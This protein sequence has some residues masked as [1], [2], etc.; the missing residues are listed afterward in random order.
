MTA[1]P[2]PGAD[3]S[4]YET[5]LAQL[6]RE[7]TAD[8]CEQWA[9]EHDSDPDVPRALTQAGWGR[10]RKGAPEEAFEL[11][12]DARERG[13]D[14][15]R[16]AQVGLIEILYE[17]GRA[18]EGDAARDALRAEL[19]RSSPPDL[20]IYNEIVEVLSEA[21]SPQPEAALVWCEAALARAGEVGEDDETAAEHRHDLL[22]NRSLVREQLGLEPD[23][24]DQAVEAQADA[25]ALEVFD[26]LQDAADGPVDGLVLRWTRGDLPQVRQRWPETA[27]EY[28]TDYDT[29]AA[30]L[31][32]KGREYSTGGAVH[33]RMVTGTLADYDVYAK[34]TGH[35]PDDPETRVRYMRW[36]D[37]E[38]DHETLFWP[39][40]RNGPCWCESGRK[41]KK[42]CGTPARN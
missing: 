13:G 34:R 42:C 10:A 4:P 28:G 29:Y 38:F 17:L 14:Q 31:Q 2:S 5:F 32:R 11:F 25:E 30:S 1:T 9:R 33:V 27:V 39:P 23:E 19:D 41:Y 20:R 37:S 24:L 16:D 36:R 12:R 35:D 6:G 21:S 15:A 40:P 22:L 3:Q 26:Q 8:E 7:A 18:E